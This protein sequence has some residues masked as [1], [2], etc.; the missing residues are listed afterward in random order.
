MKSCR[1]RVVLNGVQ[2]ALRGSGFQLAWWPA[3]VS[4]LSRL[5]WNDLLAR[6][7][8]DELHLTTFPLLAGPGGT[9]LFTGHPPVQF[10]LI[11]T[12][13]FPGSGNVLTVWDVSRLAPGTS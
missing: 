11:R 5:L 4:Q 2:E 8:V 12:Q 6:G 13:T 1:A 3:A 10:R 9:P 7:L